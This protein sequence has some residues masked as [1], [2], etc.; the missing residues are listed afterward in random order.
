MNI[1]WNIAL[2]F[3]YIISLFFAIF[4]FTVFL[5]EERTIKKKEI[6]NYP[7]VTVV[8]PAYN[9]QDCIARSIE[10]VLKLNYPKNK[11]E[12]L[13][14]NDGSTDNTEKIAKSTIKKHKDRDIQ[15]ITKKN[16]GKGAGMNT[17]L[18]IAKGE[19]FV[20][21]DADSFIEKD[22]LIKMIPYFTDDNI[23]AVLP[24]LKVKRPRNLLQKLQKYEYVINMFYKELMG[25]LNCVHVAPGPFSIYNKKII[26]RIGGFDEHNLVEDLE[27]ALRLQSQNYKIIQTLDTEVHTIAPSGFKALYNQRNRWYK[28]SILNAMKYK[29]LMFNKKYGDFG[30]IQMPTIILSGLVA[31]IMIV[32]I[33]YHSIKPYVEYIYNLSLVNFDIITFLKDITPN[34]HLLDLNFMTLV[35]AIVMITISIIILR[36]SHTMTNEKVVRHGLFSLVFYMVGYFLI[37]G[38]MWLGI[39]FDLIINRRQKW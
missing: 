13:V 17:A 1:I 12:V 11:L 34:F 2:W 6:K 35:V 27:I 7:K 36:K 8:I 33:S 39:T 26:Q 31:L 10:S 4:W 30:M 9:E 19:Y 24:A 22:A 16:A 23:A 18:K 37:L 3:T 25:K 28:G 14:I 5:T 20:C 21:M 15:L 32:S 29:N 38:T